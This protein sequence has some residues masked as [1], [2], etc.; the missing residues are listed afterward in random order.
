M[1]A[2]TSSI[3]SEMETWNSLVMLDWPK[4]SLLMVWQ[5]KTAQHQD[6]HMD[7]TAGLRSRTLSGLP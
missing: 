3:L 2:S 4:L 6:H 1:R 7:L 5:H